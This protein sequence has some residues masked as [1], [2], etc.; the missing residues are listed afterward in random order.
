MDGLRYY[1]KIF[2]GTLRSMKPWQVCVAVAMWAVAFVTPFRFSWTRV[3]AGIV[4]GLLFLLLFSAVGALVVTLK[5]YKLDSTLDRLGYC[6]EYLREFEKERIVNKPF[7][8]QTAVNYASIF[9]R[10]G[11]PADA[12]KYLDSLTV[13]ADA[14]VQE[15]IYYFF[16]YVTSALQMGDLAL[17][18]NKWRE[19][20]DIIDNARKSPLYSTN[21]YMLYLALIYIDCFAGN[22]NNDPSRVQRAYDQTVTYM[23]TD[24]YKRY[25]LP[26]PDF[27]IVML[28][29][30][31]YLGRTDEFNALYP[32]VRQKIDAWDPLLRVQKRVVY[33]D[34]E[35]V[36]RGELPL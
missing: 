17:A 32:R 20:Q 19:F 8:L 30:L 4:C 36:C 14:Q 3:V 33:E 16:I 7:R 12:V 26:T 27:E 34:L 1:G 29:E 10:I 23:N 11:Q 9:S 2:A 22:L 6:V 21:S 15:K 13:P 18:E 28:L 5:N 31:K 25:P 24:H 35:K